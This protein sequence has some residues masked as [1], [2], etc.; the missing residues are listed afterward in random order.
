MKMTKILAQLIA[1]FAIVATAQAAPTKRLIE[2]NAGGEQKWMTEAEIE[3][4]S[5]A[6]H[7]EGRCGGFM[8]VTDHPAEAKH[9]KFVEPLLN[10]EMMVPKQ[11]SIVQPLLR[12]VT[13]AELISK[14][15]KL[16][17][18]KNRYYNKSETGVEA[19]N[20][21]KS[22][23][24]RMAGAR[25]DL[26]VNAE[27]HRFDQP[28]VIATIPGTGPKKDEIIIIGG[29]LDSINQSA[30]FSPHKAHAPGADDNASGTASVMETYRILSESGFR[31]NRTIQFM[32]YA[33]EEKGLL[34]SQDIANRYR[35]EGKTVVAVMQLDMTMYPGA[36]PQIAMI[37]D[38]THA[39]LNS[40]TKKLIDSYLG[41]RW[42]EDQCGYAC[43]D[44]ASWTRA[45]F[46]AVMPS[47]AMK[48]D[49]NPHLHTTRDTLDKLDAAHGTL[50]IK[51][52]LAFAVEIA[53]AD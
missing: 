32:G 34:G 45:G 3:A 29:H 40:F 7:A 2:I 4:I 31:P 19:A 24:S 16:S 49:M 15:T 1:G 18:F 8:D 47:E 43:S 52:A 17:S 22:E 13:A 30:L 46:P 50:Y 44:H 35:R 10:F 21:I 9:M 39:G 37:M 36:T 42:V 25:S 14:V 33:G 12:E 26:S 38:N 23:Y 51:L 6:A 48:R 27:S 28:S 11:H 53:Q 41:V 5:Q 20:W